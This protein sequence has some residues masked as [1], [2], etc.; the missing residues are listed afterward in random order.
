MPKRGGGVP[1]PA[2]VSLGFEVCYGMVTLVPSPA[3]VMV[4]V[5]VAAVVA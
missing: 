1:L 4:K 2:A 3:L 5:P